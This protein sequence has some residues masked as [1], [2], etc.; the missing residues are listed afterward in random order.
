MRA[1]LIAAVLTLSAVSASAADLT[2]SGLS[3]ADGA[4]VTQLATA[5]QQYDLKA[6]DNAV[7]ALTAAVRPEVFDTLSAPMQY[8]VLGVYA[9]AQYERHA[10]SEAHDAFVTLTAN[11]NATPEDWVYRLTAASAAGDEAD[12]KFA[13]DRL[14]EA[15][16]PGPAPGA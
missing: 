9:R 11:A 13:Y 4:V 3:T 16:V 7:D 8:G 10:W 6:Y 5:K 14:G 2:T 1:V 15:L 12:A